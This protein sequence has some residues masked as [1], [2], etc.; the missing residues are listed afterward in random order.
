M[1]TRNDGLQVSA[2]RF[3][4]APGKW[5]DRKRNPSSAIGMMGR[6]GVGWP[7]VLE[8]VAWYA[9]ASGRPMESA[10]Y[11]DVYEQGK[12]ERAERATAYERIQREAPD[13]AAL[14]RRVRKVFG[15]GAGRGA[16]VEIGGERVW[17]TRKEGW[18]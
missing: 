6:A 4:Y 5:L 11:R 8:Y 2:K 7:T 3:E 10:H 1:E 17:P 15:P 14:M 12:R 13:V 18:G 16:T 9:L